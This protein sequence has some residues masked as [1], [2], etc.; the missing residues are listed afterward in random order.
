MSVAIIKNQSVEFSELSMLVYSS[1]CVFSFIIPL[2]LTVAFLTLAERKVLAAMQRRRGPNIVGFLGLMQPFAD[3]LKLLFKET[4][5]PSNASKFLFIFSPIFTLLIGLMSWAVVPFSDGVVFANLAFGVLYLF[6]TSSLGVYGVF[7]AGWASNSRYALLGALRSAAQMISYEVSLGLI[8]ISL[9]ACTHSLNLTEIV[10]FQ[11][12][13]WF[14]IPFWPLFLMFFIS[15]VAETNRTPFDLP[16][17]EGELVSGYNV[18]YSAAGFALFFVAEYTNIVLMSSL[19]VIFFCGG[20]LPVGSF[21][22]ESFYFL[23]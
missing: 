20:W 21:L 18:E 12:Y 9:I 3:A 16:E 11:R 23:F 4:I 17:A 19:C 13:I 7:V 10:L 15:I 2:L 8:L 14:I 1:F 5:I 6:A 22:T